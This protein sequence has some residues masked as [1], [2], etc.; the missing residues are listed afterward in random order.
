M[1]DRTEFMGKII[2]RSPFQASLTAARV[3]LG[4]VFIY[5]GAIKII[6]PA[7]FAL[8]V[9]NYHILPGRLVNITA[10]MLPWV[11]VIAGLSLVLGLWTPGGALII[12]G[13]LLTFTITMGFNLSRGLDVSCGC[14]SSSPSG[15]II[16]WWYLL[17]DSSLLALSLLVLFADQG[18]FSLGAYLHARY[19][20]R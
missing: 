1:N 12:S 7:G 2:L 6:D 19:K 18:R 3:I 10:I 13:L 15:N 16:T 20:K 8:A 17:R 4:A 14:F 9:Y 11:E 5:A